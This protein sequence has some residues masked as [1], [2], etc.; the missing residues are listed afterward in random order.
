MYSEVRIP[1]ALSM[2]EVGVLQSYAR[3]REV[4]EAG[5]LLGFSTVHMA[6][7][8]KRVVS[9]D[10]HTGYDRLPNDTYRAF[11][12][13]LEVYNVQ[14]RVLPVVGDCSLLAEHDGDF[15][16]ID[17]DGTCSTTLRAIGQCRCPFIGVHDYARQNCRGVA[18]AVELAGL[19]VRERTDSLII[20]ER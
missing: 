17:L 20:L 5:A 19:R 7:V 15:G 13:N 18:D 10:R 1:T 6:K 12:R 16:F 14:A 9:I 3:G 8:A 4:V 2:R 11:R